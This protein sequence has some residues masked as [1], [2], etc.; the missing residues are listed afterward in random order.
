MEIKKPLFLI[1]K[2]NRQIEQK[3]GGGHRPDFHGDRGDFE[4]H[5]RQRI[6]DVQ[7]II[8]YFNK[9]IELEGSQDIDKVFFEIKFDNKA[10]AKSAQPKKL[11]Q[12][13][14]IDLYG[15]KGEQT[16][17]ASC[18]KDNFNS[19]RDTIN[20][21]TLTDPS[22]RD[23]T[24]DS[25]YLSAILGIKTISQ[26]EILVDKEYM[27]DQEF[28]RGYIYLH[29]A[30]SE[31]EAE[32]IFKEGIKDRSEGASEFFISTT[33]AKVIYG[34]FTT[35]FIEQISQSHP[36]NPILK[37]EKSLEFN[38]SRQIEVPHNIKD[39]IL[40]PL[41][42][43]A[44]V[45]IFDSGIT[46]H[47]IYKDLILGHENFTSDEQLDKLGHGTFVA[48][49]A[50]FGNNIHDQLLA[51][52]LKPKC[53]VVDFKIFGDQG[54][55]NDKLILDSIK[56]V[57]ENTKFSDIKIINLSLNSNDNRTVH[58]GEKH[59]LTRELDALQYKYNVLFVVSAGNHNTSNSRKYPDCL[60][61]DESVITPPADLINGLSVGSIAD[62]SSTNAL[63]KYNE[64]SPFSRAGLI[65]AIK[66]PDLTHFGGNIDKYGSCAGIGSKGISNNELKLLESC[67]TSF[68]APLV[69]QIAAQIYAYLLKS[70]IQQPT[71]DLVKALLIHSANYSLP[72][73]SLISANDV[74]RLVG[75]GIPDLNL[76]LESTK[77][78]C[79]FIYSDILTNFKENN[80]KDS[81]KSNKHKVRFT[82]PKEIEAIDK[83]S[84]KVKGTLVYS[85]Q[86]S[87]SGDVDYALSDIEM[88]LHRYNSTNTKLVSAGL[89]ESEKD[90]RI[91]WNPIKTFEK[92]F[93]SF[94][95][96]D[97]EIWLTLNTRDII[98]DTEY[99][100]PYALVITIE[101]VSKSDQKL[102]LHE[103]IKVN[104]SQYLEVKINQRI[105]Q[106]I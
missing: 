88:N 11:L 19:F 40:E 32:K 72:Q 93:S 22:H 98:A 31:N 56:K 59:H 35:N 10:V 73:G 77:S 103:I 64:P 5:K 69:S 68:S 48:T 96:G 76:S 20:K 65:G 2:T 85:P 30:L 90:Y 52:V 41:D 3:P 100:Q 9:P 46:E 84:V 54:I 81:T 17:V 79:T 104:Y 99:K 86:I 53:K 34:Q 51:G 6:E 23:Y 37:I 67:G 55:I 18:Q 39:I 102:D 87:M 71:M 21:I 91:V 38:V 44:K 4:L 74:D 50:I 89:T 25:A 105:Q 36:I 97:W 66:K 101:D 58:D 28:L 27:I 82:I 1:P 8:D 70:E 80:S 47:E 7:K 94:Q 24:D 78:S 49:R 63:A 14:K 29:D 106:Q 16:F 13:N 42:F 95:G 61:D 60:F 62:L 26:E 45:A 92:T 12:D 57:L 83:K 75:F 43:D 33:G 15:Q